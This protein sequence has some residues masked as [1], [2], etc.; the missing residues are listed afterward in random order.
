MYSGGPSSPACDDA[1]TVF[2]RSLEDPREFLGRMAEF[3]GI[4]ANADDLVA[5]RQRLV[6]RRECRFFRKMAQKTK[7]QRAADAKLR[8]CL[9]TRPLEAVD[10][11]GKW[12]AAVGVRLRIEE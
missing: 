1:Q 4:K 10:N 3:A 12:H 2:S 8:L 6:E 7:D 11:R 5:M 9:I